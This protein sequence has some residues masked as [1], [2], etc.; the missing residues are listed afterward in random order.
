MNFFDATLVEADGKL[1]VDSSSFRLEIPPRL[2]EQ[3]RKYKGREV[4]FGIRPEDI[5]AKPYVPPEISPAEL[6]ATVDVVELMGSEIFLYC[7]TADH[8]SFIARV[9]PR[10]RARSGDTVELVINMDHMH[11]FDPQTEKRLE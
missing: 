1:Y 3:Y 7:L 4:I 9:D 5:H 8:K 2:A 10:I 6:R 11:L